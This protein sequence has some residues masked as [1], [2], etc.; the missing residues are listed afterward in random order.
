M[1]CIWGQRVGGGTEPPNP[2]ESPHPSQLLPGGGRSICAESHT[3]GCFGGQGRNAPWPEGS[4][5]G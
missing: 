2:R 3:V 4:F 5:S 1:L